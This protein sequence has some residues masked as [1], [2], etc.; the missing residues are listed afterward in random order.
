M[1]IVGKRVVDAFAQLFHL[2]AQGVRLGARL[3]A[4]GVGSGV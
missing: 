3:L 1:V 4:N 2:S